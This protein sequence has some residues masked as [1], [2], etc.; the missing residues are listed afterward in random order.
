MPPAHTFV[1]LCSSA[2]ITISPQA[3]RVAFLTDA[4]VQHTN[5]PAKDIHERCAALAC[6]AL[7]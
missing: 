7:D 6:A 4:G 5:A 1:K 3:Q 2:K